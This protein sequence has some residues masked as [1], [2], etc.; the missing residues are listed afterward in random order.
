MG[1]T[2][3]S[4]RSLY[5]GVNNRAVRDLR[6]SLVL[7]PE[8]RSLIYGTMLGDGSIIGNYNNKQKNYRLQ[9]GHSIKQKEL[10]LW[11]YEILK[12]FVIRPPSYRKVNDS[13]VF[14]TISHPQITE[15]YNL[16]Y[17]NGKKILPSNIEDILK[18]KLSL[19]AWYMDDGC[20][21]ISKSIERGLILN[22]QNFDL[23]EINKLVE[24]FIE[25]YEI[26]PKI[27]R[28]HNKYRLHIR[29]KDQYKFSDLF[30][31]YIID[32]LKYKLPKYP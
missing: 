17:K 30:R 16:F 26:E 15:I 5:L 4:F 2:V 7:S 21:W 18:D 24:L 27:H 28:D 29:V 23:D 25:L 13:L 10:V 9:I 3:G 32:T 14:R 6:N 31:D 8:Q 19:A 20:K 22:T 11:K 12:K 1:N